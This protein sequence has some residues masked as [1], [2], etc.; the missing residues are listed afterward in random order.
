MIIFSNSGLVKRSPSLIS[1]YLHQAHVHIAH[2][3]DRLSLGQLLGCPWCDHHASLLMS[4]VYPMVDRYTRH[5]GQCSFRMWHARFS[6]SRRVSLRELERCE[7]REFPLVPPPSRLAHPHTCSCHHSRG[8]RHS[9][10]VATFGT[11][12]GP[13]SDQLADTSALPM[14]PDP[15]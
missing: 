8:Q 14:T 6:D 11:T 7:G 1:I 4:I 9:M 10:S 13:L 2:R 15:R 5:G 12:S 3:P